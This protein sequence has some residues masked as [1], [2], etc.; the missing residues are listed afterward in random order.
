MPK[1]R[2]KICS[3]IENFGNYAKKKVKNLFGAGKENQDSHPASPLQHTLPNFDTS[4]LA[5][6]TLENTL[7]HKLDEEMAPPN[8][9][10]LMAVTPDRISKSLLTCRR[11]D[12]HHPTLKRFKMKTTSLLRMLWTQLSMLK[13]GLDPHF[14]KLPLSLCLHI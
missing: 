5:S 2:R 13:T 14:G 3:A 4:R 9:K 10:R 12:I 7:G 6:S 1:R 11:V 8:L